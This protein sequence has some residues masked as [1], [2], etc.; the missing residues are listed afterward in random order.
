ML[1]NVHPCLR[2]IEF[3]MNLGYF[4]EGEKEFLTD[5]HWLPWALL[6]ELTL[7]LAIILQ[8]G[9]WNKQMRITPDNF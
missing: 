8:Y 9:L 3:L 7:P 2:G 5:L 1:E 4:L 6:A